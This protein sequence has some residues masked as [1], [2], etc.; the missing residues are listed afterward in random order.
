[1]RENWRKIAVVGMMVAAVVLTIL[2]ACG[3]GGS[4]V[5]KSS[6]SKTDVEHGTVIDGRDGQSY[7]TVKIGELVWMAENIN[8]KTDSSWC[9]D[10]DDANCAKY[11][12]LYTWDAAMV[13]CPA[14][15]SLPDTGH[16]YNL[17]ELAGGQIVEDEK[18]SYWKIAGKRLR[19]KSS[20]NICVRYNTNTDSE[21]YFSCNGNGT[22]DFGFSAMAG[23]VAG[24]NRFDDTIFDSIGKDGNWWSATQMDLEDAWAWVMASGTDRVTSEYHNKELGLSVRCVKE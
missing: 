6:I 13:A 17:I 4:K 5:P 20:W 23:G 12:R 19:S 22:D 7:R 16:W 24:G 3:S 11:G 14:G 10:N 9:Y 1:M 8:F 2:T 18:G 21:E 15:W